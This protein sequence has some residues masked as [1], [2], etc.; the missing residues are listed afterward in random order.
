MSNALQPIPASGNQ[1]T[2]TGFRLR[3]YQALLEGTTKPNRTEPPQPADTTPAQ[4]GVAV[5]SPDAL[6]SLIRSEVARGIAYALPH[7]IRH[8]LR[9][10]YLTTEEVLERTGWSTGKLAGMRRDRRIEFI[11]DGGKV[12]YRN[13]ALDALLL[14]GLVP[15]RVE[16]KAVA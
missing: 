13:D 14:K 6:A 8:A 1:P 4:L 7:A 12:L 11:K 15:V 3:F 9:K 2:S 16:A 5:M 10:E